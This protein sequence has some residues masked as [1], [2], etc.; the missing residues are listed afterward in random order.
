VA[1][2]RVTAADHSNRPVLVIEGHLQ[3]AS[4]TYLVPGFSYQRPKTT[5]LT[6]PSIPVSYREERRFEVWS[7][8]LYHLF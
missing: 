4:R 1:Y 3:L 7:I 8:S 6:E 5:H 2:S